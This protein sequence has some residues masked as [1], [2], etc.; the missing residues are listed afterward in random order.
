[1]HTE[2]KYQVFVSSTYKD[3]VKERQEVMQILLEMDCIP[4]G[5]ELFPAADDDQWT[6]IQEFIDDCDYYLVISAGRYGTLGTS[7]LSYTE[8]EYRY[9]IGAGIPTIAFIHQDIDSISKANS[10]TTEKGQERLSSFHELLKTKV[11]KFWDTPEKLGSVVSRSLRTLMKRRPGIGWVRG[12]QIAS[13][14]ASLEILSL[15]KE[16]DQ[17]KVELQSAS[18]SAPPGTED[19][20]QGEDAL[21]IRYTYRESVFSKPGAVVTHWDEVLYVVGPLMLQECSETQLKSTLT[22]LVAELAGKKTHLDDPL[23]IDTLELDDNDFQGVKFQLRALG[24]ITPSTRQRSVKDTDQ[25]W[26]LTPYGG[27][28]VGRLRA[29]RR[30][31]SV[32]M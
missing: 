3:L 21:E 17:L 1:M 7:D 28:Q 24:L 16:V 4:A 19:L 26:T 18:Q 11:C 15:R 14:D 32:D 12:N 8:M 27:T 13:T 30:P 25:Y 10:E 22:A 6:L 9:A 23:R 29:R 31:A 20:Q 2:K 5:M